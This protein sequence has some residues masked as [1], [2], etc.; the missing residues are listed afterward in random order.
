MLLGVRICILVEGTDL[1]CTDGLA[2]PD[3]ELLVTVTIQQ[4][5]KQKAGVTLDPQM[6]ADNYNIPAL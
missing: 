5:L 1:Q 2:C 3:E 4:L 6:Y